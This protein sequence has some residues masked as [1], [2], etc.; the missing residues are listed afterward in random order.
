MAPRRPPSASAFA[1]RVTLCEPSRRT[2]LRHSARACATPEGFGMRATPAG[3][4]A[5]APHR[6]SLRHSARLLRLPLKGGVIGA[7]YAG[8]R[9][10]SPLEGE[11]A[12]GRSPS[13][14]RRGANAASKRDAPPRA[15]ASRPHHV[16]H[17][18]AFSAT[19]IDLEPRRRSAV[20]VSADRPA[21]FSTVRKLSA[22][23]GNEA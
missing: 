21:A 1:C 10:H 17:S 12:R 3:A 15:R 6:R 8:L 14:S 7:S 22:S 23:Q 19:R 4:S 5:L 13:S 9:Y 16:R 20:E 2:S 18:L 11:S